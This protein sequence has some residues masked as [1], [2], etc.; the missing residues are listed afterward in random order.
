MVFRPGRDLGV[1]GADE[2]VVGDDRRLHLA[3][4]VA[5]LEV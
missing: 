2:R 5:Q 4:G 3:R 1:V